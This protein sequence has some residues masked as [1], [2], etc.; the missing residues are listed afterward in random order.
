L[1]SNKSTKYV[2]KFGVV[3]ENGDFGPIDKDEFLQWVKDYRDKHPGIALT[4]NEEWLILYKQILA[5]E[6][7]EPFFDLSERI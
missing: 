1:T 7:S 6:Y 5:K 4:S 2:T 3:E